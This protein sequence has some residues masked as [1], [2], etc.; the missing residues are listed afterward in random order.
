M[1]GQLPAGQWLLVILPTNSAEDIHVHCNCGPQRCGFTIN[2][3]QESGA[4]LLLPPYPGGD[5]A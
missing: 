5:H 2:L 4:P 1:L 3:E